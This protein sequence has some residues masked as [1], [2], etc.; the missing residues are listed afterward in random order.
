MSIKHSLL[1]SVSQVTL[2][3]ALVDI[4]CAHTTFYSIGWLTTTLQQKTNGQDINAIWSKNKCLEKV[5][6]FSQ[7]L[8]PLP[9]GL[10]T[11]I[12][13]NAMT[14]QA[15]LTMSSVLK[16]I[17]EHFGTKQMDTEGRVQLTLVSK[18]SLRLTYALVSL[19]IF[20]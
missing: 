1:M 14:S 6:L 20:F 9:T 3:L 16:R 5:Y 10:Q 11:M 13:K 18:S 17:R 2:Q 15:T 7:E 8:H 12:P 19:Q 4:F